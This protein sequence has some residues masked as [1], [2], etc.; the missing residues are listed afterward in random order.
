MEVKKVIEEAHESE[1][2]SIA[3][4]RARREIFTSADGDKVIKA[5][6]A[7][8]CVCKLI[9][10][11]SLQ[12]QSSTALQVW[13]SRSGMLLRMQQ[14]HKGMVTCLHFALNV[15]LLF[16]GSIDN[17]VGIWTEKGI[18]LQA[19]DDSSACSYLSSPG[20]SSGTA[21]HVF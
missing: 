16:S 7:H 5:R 21:C 14:G 20:V 2:V 1:I 11:C 12:M 19:R 9:L 8:S 17:T 18:N 13:D 6:C 10:G 4:N 3:Y 15:K